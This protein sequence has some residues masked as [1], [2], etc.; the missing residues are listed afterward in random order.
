MILK[1]LQHDNGA[2][3]NTKKAKAIKIPREVGILLKT[4]TFG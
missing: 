4:V 3:H 1:A 2:N